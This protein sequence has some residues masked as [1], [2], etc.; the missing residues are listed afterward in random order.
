MPS[1]VPHECKWH[2]NIHGAIYLWL[3][4]QYYHPSLI[5]LKLLTF[6]NTMDSCGSRFYNI[7][8]LSKTFASDHMTTQSWAE[9]R[10]QKTHNCHEPVAATVEATARITIALNKS[11]WYLCK[12]KTFLSLNFFSLFFHRS[13]PFYNR[14]WFH[15]K[16]IS[17]STSKWVFWA[18]Q[19]AH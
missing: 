15:E 1:I 11:M 18:P 2:E 5:N 7:C 8:C 13:S 3:Q 19:R 17:N 12:K 9:F 16:K 4:Y 14:N 10:W 6:H